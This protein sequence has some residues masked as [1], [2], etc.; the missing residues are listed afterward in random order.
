LLLKI[1]IKGT[2]VWSNFAIFSAVGP[3]LLVFVRSAQTA[4]VVY[5]YFMC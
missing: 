5:T 2:V 3:I 1:V 4:H